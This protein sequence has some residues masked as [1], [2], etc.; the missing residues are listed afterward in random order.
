LAWTAYIAQDKLTVQNAISECLKCG[1]ND[2]WIWI[3]A[4][5]VDILQGGDVNAAK[6]KFEQAITLLHQ[7]R[8]KTKALTLIFSMQ[9]AGYGQRRQPGGDANYGIDKLN[10]RTNRSK[11]RDIYMNLGL[12]YRK[13]GGEQGGRL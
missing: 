4:G 7:P 10:R 1:L 2:P 6:Q 11:N 9:S 5:Q 12:C 3:G 13:L 8:E